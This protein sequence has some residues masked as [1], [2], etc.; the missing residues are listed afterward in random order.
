ML[1]G[2]LLI[3]A[4]FLMLAY[5]GIPPV[6]PMA[7]MGI[8]FALVPAVLWMAI[9][10]VVDRSRLGL[11]SAVADAVQQLGLVGTNLMIG[12]SNDRWSAGAANPAGYRPGMWI[13]TSLAMLAVLS[14]AVLHRVE[15]GP[16]GHGLETITASS[17][18]THGSAEPASAGTPAE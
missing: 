9:V 17:F 13:F 10:F 11:A 3:A 5:T 2:S 8:A 4:V 6:I 18:P 1:C 12:R 7:M 15:T 16:Q 14:A